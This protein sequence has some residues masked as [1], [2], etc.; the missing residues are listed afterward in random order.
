MSRTRH[1]GDKAKARAFGDNWHWMQ[2]Y[3]GWWDRLFHHAP[4]RRI[5]RDMLRRGDED[6]YPNH[7]RP[8][9]YYW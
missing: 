4:A 6:G 3:P 7:R 2:N 8:H 1:H 5:E 9:K